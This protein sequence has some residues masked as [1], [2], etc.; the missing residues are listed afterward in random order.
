MAKGPE[1]APLGATPMLPPPA[2]A[3]AE[4]AEG[5]FKGYLERLR[6]EGPTL[7]PPPQPPPPSPPEDA[8][9]P[10]SFG[11]G[12]RYYRALCKVGA[13]ATAEPQTRERLPMPSRCTGGAAVTR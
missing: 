8:P 7:E 9:E 6:I 2:G 11:A 3:A 12:R 10:D 1:D 13:G 5:A 4:R